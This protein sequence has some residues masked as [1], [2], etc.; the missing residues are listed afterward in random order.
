[1]KPRHE[2]TT[3]HILSLKGFETFLPL[4]SRVHRYGGREREYRLPLFPGYLF[5]RF[6]LN[7][8][9]PVLST[10]SVNS[11]AGAGRK[12]LPVEESEVG[13]LRIAAASPFSLAP[14]AYIQTGATVRVMEG[15]LTGVV[16]TVVE[17]HDS[18]RL[19]LSIT[20]LR[21][22]VA[23]VLDRGYLSVEPTEGILHR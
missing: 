14:H 3:G 13:S 6:D 9:L 15:P 4:Y 8:S 19:V 10:P 2:K 18:R 23:L 22:S 16:G 21:R 11:L 7:E 20:M 17:N 1:V 5:C 12:P